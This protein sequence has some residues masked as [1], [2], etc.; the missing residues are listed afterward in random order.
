[1]KKIIF[2]IASFLPLLAMGQGNWE[3]LQTT[4]TDT[5]KTA[6]KG[7]YEYAK[8]L[9]NVVPMK[10]G[11]VV[12]EKTITNNKSAEENYAAMLSY[13]TVMTKEEGQLKEST[14]ALVNKNEHKIVCHFE[15]WLVFSSNF[16]SLDRTRLIYTLMAECY[17]NKVQVQIFRINYWY[18]ELR[19]GGQR[20]KAEEWITDKW[21]LNKKKTKLAKISGKFRRK[22]VDRM[23]EILN[24]ITT[25]L[26]G[27]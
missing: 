9:G 24:N 8:Y 1:M 4:S 5:K 14:V 20:Y 3:R 16:I 22:T 12:W 2:I 18:D 7:G 27:N 25:S 13:L 26:I 23:E 10:D 15:E 11:E 21:G 6:D 17:D 19:N